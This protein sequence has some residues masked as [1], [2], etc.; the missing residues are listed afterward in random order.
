L[1]ISPDLIEELYDVASRPKLG[2]ALSEIE[3][4]IASLLEI[5]K[6]IDPQEKINLIQDESDNRILELAYEGKSDNI[7]TGDE[8][9]L[10]L[11][12]FKG[13][14]ILRSKDFLKSFKDF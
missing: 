14:R 1:L 4:F 13:I 12:E 8:H 3:D 9:L 10:K 7:I 5:C 11:G 2:F 6:F